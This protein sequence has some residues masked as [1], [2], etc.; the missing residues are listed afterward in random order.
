MSTHDL[1]RV[2]QSGRL[3]TITLM[4]AARR[5][6]LGLAMFDALDRALAHATQRASCASE[7]N[8]PPGA[9]ILR[10]R[11]DGPTFCAGF[12]LEACAVG[13]DDGQ[14]VLASLLER[15]SSTVRT[16]R[17][18]PW[19][20]VAE[21]QG[22][23]LAGGCALLT[24]CDF[25][26]VAENAQLGYPVH[27]IG[28][29][30]AVTA[31]TLSLTMGDGAA[32]AFLLSGEVIS[33]TE[34]QRRGLATCAVPEHALVPTVDALVASLLTKGPVALLTTRRLLDQ[35]DGTATNERFDRALRASL[36]NCGSDE[37][38]DMLRSFWL[39]RQ[40]RKA[41]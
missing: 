25:V 38:R 39:S 12:D 40:P 16:I 33:G 22:A 1:V 37:S 5:N 41:P 7:S 36:E 17:R 6:A 26:M 10:V 11:G 18:G 15:L 3:I 21:V 30:P 24:A 8:A 9:L 2:E 31:P 32:R 19:V 34:A 28:V 29:S 4:D 13:G 27:R 35:L 23:A 14:R 20:A